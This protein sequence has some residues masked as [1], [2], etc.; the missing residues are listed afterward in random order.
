MN[1]TFVTSSEAETRALASDLAKSLKP[2]AVLCLSGPLGSGKTRFV[3]GLAAGLGCRGRVTSPTFT[4]VREYRGKKAT[5]YHVDL[6]RVAGTDLR[7]MGLDDYLLD[8]KGICAIE[9]AEVAGKGLPPGRLEIA[10]EPLGE[11]KRRLRIR[12]R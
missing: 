6:Y 11:T 5:L 2:G 3:Q 12:S 8:P 4:L 7:L 9:W 1:R 10:I